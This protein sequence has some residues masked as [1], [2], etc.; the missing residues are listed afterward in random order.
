MHFKT[1]LL[2]NILENFIKMVYKEQQI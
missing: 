2:R 1:S